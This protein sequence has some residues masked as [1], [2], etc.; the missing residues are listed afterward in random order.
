MLVNFEKLK[1]V[2][3]STGLSVTRDKAVSGQK[4]PYIVYSHVS[5]GKKM[6]SSVVYK[7][8]PYYQISLFTTGTEKDLY[9]LEKALNDA[10]ISYSSFSSFKN[11]E[12]D[13]IVT[14]F[15]SYVRCVEDVKK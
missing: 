13:E 8:L 14:N 1:K 6:A 4:Y 7:K 15:Y 10:G 9:I 3:K 2:L 12:N 11:D 5:E